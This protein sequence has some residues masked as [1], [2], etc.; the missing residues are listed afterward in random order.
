MSGDFL[1]S[2]IYYRLN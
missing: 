1:N 2:C